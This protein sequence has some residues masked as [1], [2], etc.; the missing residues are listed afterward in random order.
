MG[1]PDHLT[2][3]LRNLYADQ[4]AT[5]WIGHGTTDWFQIG[6]GVCQ[7]VCQVWEDSWESLGLQAI[8]PVHRKGN[9]SWIFIGRTDAEA[10]TPI[11][12]PPDVKNW[13]IWKDP[14][15]GKIG[16]EADDRGWDGWMAL[17]TQ[18]TWVWVSSRSWWWTG[19]P[20]LLQ[21]TG[22]QRVGQDYDWTELNFD[23]GAALKHYEAEVFLLHP[24]GHGLMDI[25]CDA[26]SPGTE[27]TPSRLVQREASLSPVCTTRCLHVYWKWH[28]I[29][30]RKP[31]WKRLPGRR[32]P[33]R[34][35]EEFLGAPV[36][37]Q[38]P[39]ASSL[40]GLIAEKP[41]PRTAFLAGRPQANARHRNSVRPIVAVS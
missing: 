6:K 41:G 15:A 39:A 7:G 22:L 8:Q 3:L 5:V 1:I 30:G 18:W 37:L 31:S 16:G 19:K 13:L 4:E 12:W 20:V 33:T 38:E 28:G 35:C 32:V 34:R 21:S 27:W 10:E 17:P 36:Y 40:S 26:R 11:L 25:S 29:L 24:L 2:C 14:D 9:Q 23:L